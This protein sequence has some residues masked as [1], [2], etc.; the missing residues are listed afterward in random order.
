MRKDAVVRARI[1]RNLK[2]EAAQVLSGCGLEISDALRLFLQQVVVHGGIPFSIEAR[3][4]V[5]YVSAEWMHSQ[6]SSAQARDHMSAKHQ[7]LSDGSRLLIRPADLR[8]AK[9]HWSKAKQ[10]G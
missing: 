10:R 6:K 1:D 3:D 2:L 9:A 8:G 5:H 7:S 4:K